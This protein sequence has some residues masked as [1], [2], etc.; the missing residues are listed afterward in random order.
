MY[1]YTPILA[2]GPKRVHVCVYA[3][4]R[5]HSGDPVTGLFPLKKDVPD[6]HHPST[7][8]LRSG[9]RSGVVRR[10][11]RSRIVIVAATDVGV[12]GSVMTNAGWWTRILVGA[13]IP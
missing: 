9:M 13:A 12:T 1:A 11:P 4:N 8:L 10:L 6:A 5:V 7:T 3:D 2:R